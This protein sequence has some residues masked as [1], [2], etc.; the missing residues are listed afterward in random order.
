VRQL[1]SVLLKSDASLNFNKLLFTAISF[2][3]HAHFLHSSGKMAEIHRVLRLG[4]I[5]LSSMWR[6]MLVCNVSHP[7]ICI[8]AGIE[9]CNFVCS[10]CVTVACVQFL[11][12]N[13]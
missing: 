12:E 9:L 3:F 5:F 13:A 7:A 6:E 2:K 4:G 10:R 11:L 8:D 1:T